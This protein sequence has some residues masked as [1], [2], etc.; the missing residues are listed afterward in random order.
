MLEP[1]L[2]ISLPKLH[3]PGVGLNEAAIH[4][5][6]VAFLCLSQARRWQKNPCG[7]ISIHRLCFTRMVTKE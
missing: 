1:Y 5:E 2:T 7:G 4:R 6:V 3:D